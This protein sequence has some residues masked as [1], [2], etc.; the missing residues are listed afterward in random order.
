MEDLKNILSCIVTTVNSEDEIIPVINIEL[1]PLRQKLDNEIIE[2]LKERVITKL[3]IK[4]I[5]NCVI[6]IFDNKESF[7]LLKCGKRNITAIEQMGLNDTLKLVDK[8]INYFNEEISIKKRTLHK[9][10]KQ[11]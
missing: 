4:V 2:D 8:E 1:Q 11:G 7:P 6:R 10:S 5:N 3:P 9:Y